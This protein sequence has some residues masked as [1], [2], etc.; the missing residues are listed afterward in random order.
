[1]KQAAKI[2]IICCIAW[3]TGCKSE[4]PQEDAGVPTFVTTTGMLADALSHLVGDHA[5]VIALMGAGVDPH[6]YQATP[7]DLA[8]MNKADLILYNG[9][10]LEGK[11]QDILKKLE[12]TRTVI[13]FSDGIAESGLL[14]VTNA[15]YE[16][17]VYDPHIWFD[18]DIWSEGITALA[19]RLSENYPDWT[20]TLS[21]NRDAYLAELAELKTELVTMVEVLPEER[22]ILVTSHDAFHYFGRMLDIRVEALQGISTASEFGLRD[23]KNLV[24]LILEENIPAI[25]IESSVGDKPIR[26][27]LSDCRDRGREVRLG[28]MLYSDAMGEAGSPEGTYIGMIRHN[29]T[30]VVKGLGND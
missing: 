9:L 14:D 2:F 26:A 18:I 22:R 10:F 28:G 13:N 25:F 30:T 29:V 24:N 1:M 8:K 23:R 12:R 19:D 27:I 15:Q 17:E 16:Q 20:E 7:G 3:L 11:L 6:L 4:K 21:A 5:E